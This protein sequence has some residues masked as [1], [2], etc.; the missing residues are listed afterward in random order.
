M[1]GSRVYNKL[2]VI[3][4]VL[5]EFGGNNQINQPFPVMDWTDVQERE[6]KYV[7]WLEKSE[8]MHVRLVIHDFLYAE[9]V[10][11]EKTT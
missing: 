10:F 4:A 2:Y 11:V 5:Q 9:I 8:T 6:Y 3:E 7:A 1:V